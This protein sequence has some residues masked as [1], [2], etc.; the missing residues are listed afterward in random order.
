MKYQELTVCHLPHVT[1][2]TEQTEEEF[3][4]VGATKRTAKK[5]KMYLLYTAMIK[6]RPGRTQLL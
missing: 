5:I 1:L 4:F 3:M 6:A 2:A